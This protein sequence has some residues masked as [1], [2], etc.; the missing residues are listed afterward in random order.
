MWN[1]FINT[2]LEDLSL[3]NDVNDFDK[4]FLDYY[5]KEMNKHFMDKW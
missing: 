5:H 3:T 4:T 1:F 2:D